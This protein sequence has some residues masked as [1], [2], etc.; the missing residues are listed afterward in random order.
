MVEL[1]AGA[2]VRTSALLTG[3]DTP[4]GRAAGNALEV[5]ESVATLPAR[6]RP[7]WSRSPWPWPARC[8][9]WPGS[10]A[11]PAA[12]LADGRAL[13]A[14]RAM[15]ARPGRRPGRAAARAAHTQVVAAAESG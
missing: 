6:A 3:M 5:A 14:Y 15:I 12:A 7:T 9:R 11:D 10:T 2:G 1:G 4:L 13:A 8:S